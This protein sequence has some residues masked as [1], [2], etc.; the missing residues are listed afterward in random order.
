MNT[1]DQ[2][3]RV[4]KEFEAVFYMSYL[5]PDVHKI[6]AVKKAVY[7]GKKETLAEYY[8]KIDGHLLEGITLLEI[9]E[10]GQIRT[11]KKANK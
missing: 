6:L 5:G 7:P 11:I 3:P 8:N 9:D 4:G 10:S 2:N 1:N